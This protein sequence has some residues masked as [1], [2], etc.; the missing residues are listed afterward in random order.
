[1]VLLGKTIL[2]V[3]TVRTANGVFERAIHNLAPLRVET[4][5]D[6]YSNPKKN[7]TERRITNLKDYS[8]KRKSMVQHLV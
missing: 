8:E 2:Y 1:M 3:A 6:V 5:D 7:L 4:G